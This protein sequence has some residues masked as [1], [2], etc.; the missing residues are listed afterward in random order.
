MITALII[1]HN[2]DNTIRNIV[3]R[4]ADEQQLAEAVAQNR[5]RVFMLSWQGD[6]YYDFPEPMPLTQRLRDVLETDVPEKY[7]LRTEVAERLCEELAGR[8]VAN[9]VRTGGRGSVDRHMWDVVAEPVIWGGLQ[10]HQTPRTDGISP[11][12]N[13]AAGMGG[14]QTPIIVQPSY[15]IRKLTPRECW[16]LMGISDEDYDKAAA[17]VSATQLYKQAG[18]A[19]I[20]AIAEAILRPIFDRRNDT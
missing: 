9:T 11:C 2:P 8:E 19:L 6:Y 12:I 15:R 5:E 17:V 20:P 3:K 14:G 1:Y 4:G 13:A 18:N 10:A 7:Y 16:R